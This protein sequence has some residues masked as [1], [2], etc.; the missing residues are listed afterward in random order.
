LLPLVLFIFLFRGKFPARIPGKI[1]EWTL[2]AGFGILFVVME[3]YCYQHLPILDFRPYRIGTYIPDGMIT[4]EGAPQ[5]EYSTLLYYEKDGEVREF[6][7]ENYPWEDTTWTFVE[8]KHEL[9]LKGYEPPIH[10]FN[11]VTAGGY[12]IT[13]IVLD[14]DEYSYLLISHDLA[15]ADRDA[16]YY[17]NELALNCLSGNCSFYCLTSSPQDDIDGVISEINPVFD[18]Y[19]TDEITLKT[20]IRSNPGLLLL[21]GGVILEK[22]HY[23]DFPDPAEPDQKLLGETIRQQKVG[24]DRVTV[25]LL[26][27][28]FIGLV[29]LVYNF[30]PRN[31]HK[32]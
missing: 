29:L 28:V 3:T 18:F 21:K 14:D 5:D 26:V 15:K 32:T 9:V 4:P 8:S 22:W 19:L 11:I 1:T 17:A 23:N 16:L 13:D 20:I 27:S 30:L 24:R 6:T 12:D 31:E 2:L 7:E 25:L 10:D